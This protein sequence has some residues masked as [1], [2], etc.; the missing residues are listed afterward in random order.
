MRGPWIGITMI[1]VGGAS[2][3]GG[4]EAEG[5]EYFALCLSPSF[6]RINSVILKSVPGSDSKPTPQGE[7]SWTKRN[8]FSLLIPHD[9]NTSNE[10]FHHSFSPAHYPQGQR[11]IQ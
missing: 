10:I 9:S 6:L 3:C 11:I 1:E 4:L 7:R 2:T 5:Q 8:A